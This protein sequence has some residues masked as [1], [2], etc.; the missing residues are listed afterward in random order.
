MGLKQLGATLVAILGAALLGFLYRGYTDNRDIANSNTLVL[1]SRSQ[2][3]E[4]QSK[5]ADLNAKLVALQ[6]RLTSVQGALDA[7]MP[8]QNTYNLSPNQSVIVAGS[9]LTLGLIGAPTNEGVNINI[10]GKQHLADAGDV[11][12]IVLDPS[13]TCKVRVLRFDMFRA[14]V[15]ASC[16]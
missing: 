4:L 2:T 9:H 13:T 15:T 6:E 11:I 8:S 16:P 5:V 12:N 1:E 7:I 14:V 10:N 3:R